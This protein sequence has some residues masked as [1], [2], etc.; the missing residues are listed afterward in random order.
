[1]ALHGFLGPALDPHLAELKPVQVKE[2][3]EA[4]A[5]ADAK[6]EGL[7]SMKQTRFTRTQQ[8]ERAAKEAEQQ[9]GSESAEPNA[10]VQGGSMRSCSVNYL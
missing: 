9:Q 7:G 8:R 3:G 4:F 6:G 10:E 5:A 1:M 2:L